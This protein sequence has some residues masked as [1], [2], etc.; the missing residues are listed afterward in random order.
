MQLVS[1]GMV[2]EIGRLPVHTEPTRATTPAGIDFVSVAES[3][4]LFFGRVKDFVHGE[5]PQSISDLT[6][7]GQCCE[8]ER[9]LKGVGI[10][11]FG[12]L[13][14]F[15]RLQEAHTE[16]HL[17]ASEV[18]AMIQ[19]GS[20]ISAERMRKDELSQSLR[21]VLIAITELNESINK[22]VWSVS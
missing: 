6:E 1:A 5:L 20:W 21:R 22:Q 19:A 4:V 18:L 11:R 8:L 13:R 10:S 3:H 7:L 2:Q 12:Q 17:L 16:F 15:A 14:A 9:W